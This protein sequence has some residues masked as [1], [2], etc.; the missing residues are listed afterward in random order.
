MPSSLTNVMQTADVSTSA[1]DFLAPGTADPGSSGKLAD[2]AHVHPG[3]GSWSLGYEI[4]SQD[5]STG[6]G[7]LAANGILDASVTLSAPTGK[8][9]VGGG[10]KLLTGTWPSGQGHNGLVWEMA[11][12]TGGDNGSTGPTATGL[13][14]NGPASDGSSWNFHAFLMSSKLDVG[15]TYDVPAST[16][17]GTVYAICIAA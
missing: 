2:A 13:Y 4:V 10:F 3:S 5:I 14:Q 9:V 8:K 15:T 12:Y 6:G 16:V 11:V 7:G 17:V 1:A